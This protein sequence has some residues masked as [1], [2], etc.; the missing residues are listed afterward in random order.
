MRNHPHPKPSASF[1]RWGDASR[2]R[3]VSYTTD[4]QQKTLALI[5][6]EGKSCQKG[7]APDAYATAIVEKSIA[8]HKG[9][10]ADTVGKFWADGRCVKRDGMG[11]LICT[12]GSVE[13][14]SLPWQSSK[15]TRRG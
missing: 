6:E 5:E 10:A 1:G 9:K 15:V 3:V 14:A 12:D 4:P 13:M 2:N 11:A 7:K 8:N